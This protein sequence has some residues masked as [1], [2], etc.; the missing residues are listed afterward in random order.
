MATSIIINALTTKR[1]EIGA[2][3]AE[4]EHQV[5]QARSDLAHLDATLRLFDPDAAPAVTHAKR[6]RPR[7]HRDGLFEEGEI[8]RRCRE[9][10]RDRGEPISAETIVRQVMADKA[11]DLEDARLRRDLIGRFLMA[12]HRMHRARQVQKIG[13]GL[14]T[15]WGLP[16]G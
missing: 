2:L 3:I 5:R 14:G 15:L 6:G 9:C 4:L 13:H 7:T 12:L 8:S 16:E 10:L 1:T 11:L